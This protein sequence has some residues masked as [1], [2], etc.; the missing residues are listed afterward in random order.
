MTLGGNTLV[1]LPY[2]MGLSKTDDSR[3]AFVICYF[4]RREMSDFALRE[5]F[6]FDESD[7]FANRSG[8]LSPKQQAKI[9]EIEKGAN[10]I[11]VWAGVV[12]ILLA[13]AGTY[14]IFRPVIG[15]DWKFTGI[16]DVV[17]PILGLTVI[18]GIL[19]FLTV[20]SF[21]LSRSSTDS[22]IQ[23]VEGKVNFVKAEKRKSYKTASG[24][25]SYRTVEEY[26]LRVGRIAFEDVE[27]ELLNIIEEGDTYAFYYTRKTKDILSCEFISKG[28]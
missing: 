6:G 14:G 1:M 22:S 2:K 4:V 15:S 28:Q 13:L 18:W 5:F 27:E 24:S 16:S 8:R 21:R 25:T 9:N 17:G 11:F 3:K 7:L 23:K 26:E 20:G 19:G 10:Q 12:F